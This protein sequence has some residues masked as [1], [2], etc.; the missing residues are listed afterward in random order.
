MVAEKL[1][2]LSKWPVFRFSPMLCWALLLGILTHV[3]G[4]LVFR[5]Q[6]G[7]FTGIEPSAPFVVFLDGAAM[8]ADS[9]ANER[10]QLFDSAPLFIPTPWNAA[11]RDY[12]T[13]EVPAA[14][15]FEDYLPT[16]S[17]E[18]EL[19]PSGTFGLRGELVE[20]PSDFLDLRFLSPFR[21]FGQTAQ[22]P[23][24]PLDHASFVRVQVM[25]TDPGVA[26]GG[27]ILSPL[28]G[29]P[30]TAG[31]SRPVS[32]TLHLSSDGRLL[33]LPILLESSG[34]E[35]LDLWAQQWLVAPERLASLPGGR[36]E[37]TFFF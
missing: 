22:K 8:E 31:L 28:S 19:W 21:T 20:G 34:R 33:S 27:A 3:A 29:F 7:R 14:G 24:E 13:L 36:L 6:L 5:V 26:K 10:A 23:V 11:A 15:N 30:E 4:F 16:I 2:I 35:A 37:V 17:L 12:R 25:T 32:F 9:L 18:Q 1:G